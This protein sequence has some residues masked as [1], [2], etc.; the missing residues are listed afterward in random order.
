MA[1][2][3]A[4]ASD[5]PMIPTPAF[6]EP[7]TTELA[8]P[9]VPTSTSPPQGGL[10]PPTATAWLAQVLPKEEPTIV[11]AQPAPTTIDWAGHF[12]DEL[13]SPPQGGLPSDSP[14]PVPSPPQGGLASTPV[15]P[16]R[17]QAP[18]DGPRHT[19]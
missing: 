7:T 18:E 10:A 8:A 2:P 5:V 13:T 14:L 9:M 1:S 6:D 16:P 19:D 17:G 3:T 4:I 15:E 12:R 11:S